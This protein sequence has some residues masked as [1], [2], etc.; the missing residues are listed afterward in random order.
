MLQATYQLNNQVG[1]QVDFQGSYQTETQTNNQAQLQDLEINIW[2][3]VYLFQLYIQFKVPVI[4]KPNIL[5][6]CKS[7][8]H[9]L[10]QV[11]LQPNIFPLFQSNYQ[12]SKQETFQLNPQ[13]EIQQLL[14]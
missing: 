12:V 5:P 4:G 3:Q 11:K 9:Q 6:K 10:R 14:P 1:T 13:V 7:S 8:S 2:T